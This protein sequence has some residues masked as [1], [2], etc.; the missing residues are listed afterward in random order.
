MLIY[1]ASGSYST[2]TM[3]C[4]REVGCHTRVGRIDQRPRTYA[5][6]LLFLLISVGEAEDT[7]SLCGTNCSCYLINRSDC[8]SLCTRPDRN[9]AIDRRLLR[10]NCSEFSN[11][12]QFTFKGTP[13]FC[14]WISLG[15]LLEE[16]LMMGI[17]HTFNIIN[18]SLGFF[19]V[20]PHTQEEA[21]WGT[22]LTQ[23]NIRESV[24]AV[25]LL[26]KNKLHR[27]TRPTC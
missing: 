9:G 5:D 25:H 7:L 26:G 24:T 19:P 15:Q 22:K 12:P 27:W 16:L 20:Q 2:Y 4:S 3:T 21:G 18:S 10:F 14:W 23:R 6:N 1:G 8:R 13:I 11:H 17:C